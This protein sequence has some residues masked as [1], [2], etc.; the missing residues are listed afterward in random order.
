MFHAAACGVVLTLLADAAD[1][2]DITLSE[3]ACNAIL[4]SILM[5]KKAAAKRDM[6]S[7][8]IALR[9]QLINSSSKDDLR[10]TEKAVLLEWLE[11]L[12]GKNC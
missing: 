8:A 9:A 6:P 7:T 11:R 2:R 10:Q 12:T 3:I 4:A 1:A 5:T